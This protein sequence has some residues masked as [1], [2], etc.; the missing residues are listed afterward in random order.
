VNWLWTMAESSLAQG[1]AWL[2][3]SYSFPTPEHRPISSINK[4]VPNMHVTS[5]GSKTRCRYTTIPSHQIDAPSRAWSSEIIATQI[6]SIL[7]TSRLRKQTVPMRCAT[8]FPSHQEYRRN[9][10]SKKVENSPSSSSHP[11][12]GIKHLQPYSS[13]SATHPFT[14]ALCQLPPTSE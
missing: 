3:P 9:N 14:R 8:Q 5:P 10:K 12:E 4:H 13:H 6:K 1:P 7:R 11:K 2:A